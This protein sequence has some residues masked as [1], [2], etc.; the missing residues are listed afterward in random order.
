M[1]MVMVI[2]IRLG[3]MADWGGSRAGQM[4]DRTKSVIKSWTEGVKYLLRKTLLKGVFIPHN[5]RSKIQA[6]FMQISRVQP[7][8]THRGGIF[9]P[10]YVPAG[11]HGQDEDETRSDCR[12]IRGMFWWGGKKCMEG[13]FG[14][15]GGVCLMLP[16][17]WGGGGARCQHTT[18][19]PPPELGSASQ[20]ASPAPARR[21]AGRPY[22]HTAPFTRWEQST[23][24]RARWE[25][26]N[27]RI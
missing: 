2:M 18:S 20:T 19:A 24:Q 23:G 3:C 7:A 17:C 25:S 10:G 11:P 22:S 5:L 1:M 12:W 13:G 9:S 4:D 15:R 8:L 6:E 26:T 27:T 16:A 14:G 21:P